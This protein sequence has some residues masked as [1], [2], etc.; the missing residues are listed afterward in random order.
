MKILL[1][2]S[3]FKEVYDHSIIHASGHPL[4]ARPF[5]HHHGRSN[6][7]DQYSSCPRRLLSISDLQYIQHLLFLPSPGDK[8]THSGVRGVGYV[9]VRNTLCLFMELSAYGDP[10]S[11]EKRLF[12]N[13]KKMKF[14][15]DPVL[16]C[17]FKVALSELALSE[18][19]DVLPLF[20]L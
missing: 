20:L 17:N 16:K 15:T 18:P 11:Q 5:P 6:K 7:Q 14:T 19:S 4:H 2:G 13:T 9:I 12:C 3:L 8:S 1:T 10:A